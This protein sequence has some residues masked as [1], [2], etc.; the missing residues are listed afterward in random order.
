MR[1]F[2]QIFF[3]LVTLTASAQSKKQPD[4]I[5]QISTADTVIFIVKTSGCFDAGTTIYK[6]AKQKKNRVVIWT[7]NNVKETK[8]LSAKDYTA[9]V[10]NYKVS[11]KRFRGLDQGV[12][13][14]ITE[15]ELNGKKQSS[16]FA[17][18]SCQAEY[19]PEEVLKQLMK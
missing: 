10:N 13:T 2:I 16:K 1:G 8:K 18:R 6:I 11:E 19:N 3:I 9:F 12:C 14:L 15:F 4:I 17:N 7:K 5:Q